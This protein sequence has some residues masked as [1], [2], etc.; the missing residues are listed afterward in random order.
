MG[1][2]SLSD[3]FLEYRLMRYFSNGET[4]GKELKLCIELRIASRS[5][6]NV[7]VKVSHAVLK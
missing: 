2:E 5:W 7:V 3:R 6:E 4:A 1:R